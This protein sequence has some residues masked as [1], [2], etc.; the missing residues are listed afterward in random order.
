MNLPYPRNAYAIAK[1]RE[2]GLRPSGP[3]IVALNGDPEWDNAT[4][5]ADPA[6]AYRWDWV[7]GLPSVVVL[8]G[9]DTR[10]GSIL[11]DIED[12][13]P[14]QLDVIDTD[15]QIGWLVLSAKKRLVTLRWP[16][17]MVRDWLGE[18]T[19]HDGV[20]EIKAS[21]GLEIA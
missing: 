5:Y 10:F 19:W 12:C 14:G 3:V 1:A 4:V 8:I 17:W 15:R 20:N 9:K 16:Q 6:E 2:N 7:K 13:E 18:S 21:F 11:H